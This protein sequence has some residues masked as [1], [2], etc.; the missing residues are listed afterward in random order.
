MTTGSPIDPKK[1]EAVEAFLKQVD[2]PDL[3]AY[4]KLDMSADKAAIEAALKQRR[5]WAQGQ[6][7][8]PKY[9]TEAV[10]IIKN[11]SALHNVL[12]DNAA[13]YR[14]HLRSA[15]A[16]E[17]LE[18]LT[19]YI[20]GAIADGV[21]TQKAEAAILQRGQDQGLSQP[22]ILRHIE[23]LLR[24]QGARRSAIGL[25]T[26]QTLAIMPED[27]ER[28]R[29]GFEPAAASAPK[30][31]PTTP[32][33]PI[34]SLPGADDA[35]SGEAPPPPVGLR[36]LQ[37]G[38]ANAT[39]HAPQLSVDAAA[40]Q[41][42]VVGSKPVSIQITVRNT[43]LGRMAGKVAADR[44]WLQA[45][46]SRLD[47]E[48]L[49][50][51]VTLTIDPSQMSRR[52][53]QT[54]VTVSTR[55]AGNR[56]FIVQVQKRRSML[57][58][59][60]LAGVTIGATVFGVSQ[61]VTCAGSAAESSD[62]RLLIRVDPPTGEIYVDGQLT[63][64]QGVLDVTTGFPTDAPFPVKVVADGFAEWTDT[65]TVAD[66]Q[67][68]VIKPELELV[69]P[70]SYSPGPN[71]TQGDLDEA[72]VNTAIQARKTQLD[73]CFVRHVEAEPD[74]VVILEVRGVV[75]QLGD[76]ARL[77]FQERSYESSELD[78]CL[79]RQ[80]RALELPMLNPRFDYAVFEYIFH[81]TVP[82]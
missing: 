67:M 17:A 8:N 72:A 12:L 4:L 20:L 57:P 3:F 79:R 40:E 33:P 26:A 44:P 49:Q 32:P 73:R 76:V 47:P 64:T 45:K 63:S 69:D 80:F 27:R 25:A 56:S 13:A 23:T 6:Q 55:S 36:S 66:G 48:A 52:R 51:T 30:V 21:L 39:G 1:L 35:L 24:D 78:A 34:R 19:P 82:R 70:M 58:L 46:P 11:K 68:Q 65:V 53:G 81:Y 61:A 16:S 7:S 62:S 29:Q 43:G 77:D 42:V 75:N 38:Q 9:R 37:P 14:S 59:A 54:R 15:R 2:V 71:A 50:Q 10:W 60:V 28:M 41:L 18:G 74:L 22:Q 31:T 5:R